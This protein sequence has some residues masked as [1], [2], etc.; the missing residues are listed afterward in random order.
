MCRWI[1]YVGSPVNMEELISKPRYSLIHQSLASRE[2]YETTNGDGF[3]VGWYG[4]IPEPG[5][6]K[7]IEP[8]WN[9]R[10]LKV[11][12]R[13]IRSHLF[14][15]HVR[16]TTGTPVQRTNC[17][18]FSHG[19][20]MFVHNGSIREYR[21][22]RRELAFAI[23]PELYPTI[24]GTTDSELMF[25]LAL[26]FGLESDPIPALE[27][28]T[29]FVEELGRSYG[30][31]HPVQMTLGLSDGG[32]LF[33]VRY[34][35]QGQSRTLYHSRRLAALREMYPQ[36]GGFSNDSYAIVSEPLSEMSDLWECVPESSAI[37]VD[38]NG[39]NMQPF[40]PRAPA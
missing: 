38:S 2:G 33:A 31:E 4:D 30:V 29:G 25:K 34:S 22:L 9:D 20:W 19:R 8:A 37:V 17:H 13:H 23:E 10:N 1:A 24:E 3:G 40:T 27:R 39:L 14:I 11:I 26:T 5:I 7:S 18:P 16:A 21:R 35:T 32:R 6:Y 15:A 28:M 36:L 12:A